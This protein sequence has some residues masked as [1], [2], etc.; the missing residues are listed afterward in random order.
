MRSF[1]VSVMRQKSLRSVG[2]RSTSV[3]AEQRFTEPLAPLVKCVAVWVLMLKHKQPLY[4]LT[5]API[6]A[7]IIRDN[8]VRKR[9]MQ[10]APTERDTHR[11]EG[12]LA[13]QW[14]KVASKQRF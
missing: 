9:S 3:R 4:P 11:L 5:T 12:V 1:T 13:R 8:V 2:L 14:Q 7:K 10:Q 6:F